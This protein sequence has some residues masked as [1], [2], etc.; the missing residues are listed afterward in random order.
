[1]SGEADPSSLSAEEVEALER[2]VHLI[3][4]RAREAEAE[5]RLIKAQAERRDMKT[6]KRE[7][8]RGGRERRGKRTRGE[9]K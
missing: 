5:L 2:R 4:L 6:E 3:E 7:K 9:E 8:V 1:M